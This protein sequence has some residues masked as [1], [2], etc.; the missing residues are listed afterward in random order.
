MGTIIN[1]GKINK[2]KLVSKPLYPFSVEYLVVAGGGGSGVSVNNVVGKAGGSGIV[3]ISY[4]LPVK[5][6]GGNISCYA[7][8]V[9]HTFTS[10]GNISFCSTE[11]VII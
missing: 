9:I 11:I 10:S 1:K 2:G 6:T 5:A 4:P 3:I 8:K 7:G